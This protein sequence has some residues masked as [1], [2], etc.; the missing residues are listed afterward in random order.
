MT[1]VGYVLQSEQWERKSRPD[2]PR[3]NTDGHGLKEEGTVL[4]GKLFLSVFI[5]AQFQ[6]SEMENPEPIHG[7]EEFLNILKQRQCLLSSCKTW[8]RAFD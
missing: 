4:L 1:F 2:E 7:T 5:M 3:M 6:D 8:R